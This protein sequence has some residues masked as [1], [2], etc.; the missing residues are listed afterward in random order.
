MHSCPTVPIPNLPIRY[1]WF[2]KCRGKC[3][4]ICTKWIDPNDIICW[5]YPLFNTN[6]GLRASTLQ[7][8]SVHPGSVRTPPAFHATHTQTCFYIYDYTTSNHLPVHT[9]VQMAVPQ[10][11]PTSSYTNRLTPKSPWPPEPVLASTDTLSWSV[12][13]CRRTPQTL[14]SPIVLFVASNKSFSNSQY[15][16][17]LVLR[18]AENETGQR[19]R[20]WA[21]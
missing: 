18:N 2:V 4:F 15:H 16:I 17:L 3:I 10:T 12:P 9:R 7:T 11:N 8:W 5:L 19:S 1:E 6:L 21:I 20:T 13:S 14:D